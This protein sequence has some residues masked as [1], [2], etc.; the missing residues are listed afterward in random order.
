MR[1]KEMK[2]SVPVPG[3]AGGQGPSELCTGCFPRGTG[4]CARNFIC[5]IE[6][7][8]NQYTIFAKRESSLKFWPPSE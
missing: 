7:T 3:S 1:P 2:V 4:L 8:D 5:F 6:I